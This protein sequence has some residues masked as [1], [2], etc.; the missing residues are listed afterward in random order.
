MSHLHHY[1]LETLPEEQIGKINN[2]KRCAPGF[3]MPHIKENM[4]Q[5]LIM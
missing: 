3:S 2:Q 1:R 5:A 4:L